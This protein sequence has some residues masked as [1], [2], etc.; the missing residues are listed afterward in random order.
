MNLLRK[1]FPP[2][3]NEWILRSK[4]EISPTK[5]MGGSPPQKKKNKK[6]DQQK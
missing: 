6:N 5:K 1:R 3:L 4:T 2:R